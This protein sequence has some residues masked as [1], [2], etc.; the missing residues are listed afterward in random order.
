MA[1]MGI[2]IHVTAAAIDDYEWC[3]ALVA[4]SEP[5]ITLRRDLASCRDALHRLGTD[6]FVA[7]TFENPEP[8]GF[9]IVAPYVLAGSPYIASIAVAAEMRGRGIGSE[10]LRFAEKRFAKGLQFNVSESWSHSI[11][12]NSR[13]YQGVVIQDSNNI[14]GDRGNSDFDTR[15]RT[16]VSGIY[17][18]SVSRLCLKGSV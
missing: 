17:T 16:T 7:R 14:A 4:S 10:L 13:N 6:L 2:S 3:A 1:P 9:L 11:D 18:L 5:W 15:S 12:D 8:A